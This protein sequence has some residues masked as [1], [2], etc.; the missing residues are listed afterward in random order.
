[1]KNKLGVL[2]NTYKLPVLACASALLLL[3]GLESC[4]K[5][6]G[7]TLILADFTYTGA[8]TIPGPP[9]A[10]TPRYTGFGAYIGSL[11]PQVFKANFSTI[12]FQDVWNVQDAV[13]M[14]LIDNNASYDDPQR[15]ANFTSGK[16]VVL[17][18]K[19]YWANTTGR[20]VTNKPVRFEYFF[21][22]LR[23]FYQQLELPAAYK[24]V[25]LPQFN[26]EYN[27]A[28]ERGDTAQK[29]LSL[30]TDHYPLIDPLFGN[31]P[32]EFP[33]LYVFGNTDS[34]FIYNLELQPVGN[35][36]DNPMGG[37]S[38]QPIIRSNKYEPLD[39]IYSEGEEMN[40]RAVVT[41]D[42]ENLIQIYAGADDKP[43]TRDDVFVY[44]PRFWERLSVRVVQTM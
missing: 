1:M 30:K 42:Y 24:D 6:G 12:R 15:F 26:T 17:Q 33:S 16:S 20:R 13:L 21:W 3:Q 43:Y 5:D 41:F 7:K 38:I 39:F 4:K 35:N 40:I 8:D 2:F 10:D 36:K 23:W 27:Y 37:G 29:G 18:P 11:T 9:Q 19:I 25:K 34:T 32:G 44:A 31:P 14:E 22:D 28:L